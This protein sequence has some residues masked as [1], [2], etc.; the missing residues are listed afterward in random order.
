MNSHKARQLAPLKRFLYWIRERHQ[1]HRKRQAGLPYPW[2][3]DEVLQTYF[4]TNPYR[5]NDKVTRWFKTR[6]RD[7]LNDD[8]RVIFATICFRWFN[9]PHHTGAILTSPFN[10]ADGLPDF[11]NSSCLI[12]HW[13]QRALRALAAIRDQK[14]KIFT[15]A[16]MINSPAGKPKL[17]AIYDRVT[18]VWNDRKR[19]VQD[20]ESADSLKQAHKVLTRYE[21]LGGFM[22]YE[23]VCDLRFTYVLKDAVDINTWTNPGP[24]CLRGLLWLEGGEGSI[25]SNSESPSMPKDFIDRMAALLAICRRELRTMPEFEMR[26]VEHSLCEYDKYNRLLFG[27]GKSKRKF[28]PS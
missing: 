14:Q 6:I 28:K 25:K 21:G 13:G 17:E 16:F 11:D 2:T 18:A 15:G 12:T 8:R 24:G 7:P 26:E 22:A 27:T 23:V 9:L 3:D 19:L 20:L 1:I 4:F 10:K 5:E